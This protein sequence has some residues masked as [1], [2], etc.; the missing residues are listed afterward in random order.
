MNEEHRSTTHS[1]IKVESIDEQTTDIES[2]IVSK[3]D[4]VIKRDLYRPKCV[5]YDLTRQIVLDK[6]NRLNRPLIVLSPDKAICSATLGGNAERYRDLK[7]LFISHRLYLDRI[8][9]I[10]R[11]D[12]HLDIDFTKYSNHIM[13]N[14]LGLN[15]TS[16]TNQSNSKNLNI[17]NVIFLGT[18]ESLDILDTLE[19]KPIVFTPKDI[20]SKGLDKIFKFIKSQFKTHKV[21]IVWDLSENMCYSNVVDIVDQIS[22]LDIDTIDIMG[23]NFK[24]SIESIDSIELINT[25]KSMK[26]I[27]KKVDGF[28]DR[29]IN[30]FDEN[31]KFLIW[32]KIKY[33]DDP[34]G[35]Y[36]LRNVDLETR[37]QLIKHFTDLKLDLGDLGDLE[38]P[39]SKM[40]LDVDVDEGDLVDIMI[41][42]TCPAEQNLKSYFSAT[43]YADRCLMPEEKISM[44]F[45]MLNS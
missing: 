19:T 26:Y 33:S 16:Y 25:I 36:I 18:T 38:Y 29:K 5:I 3:F 37:E 30:I 17:S 15:P 34:I 31:S 7:V 8:D 12:Y 14:A 44:V 45:E 24:D 27:L 10:D 40:E 39:I 9:R 20:Q 23:Y 28:K 42:V 21:H 41:S 6:K 11:T 2:Y 13:S 4:Y 43:S 32:K 1:L 35:W 22:D